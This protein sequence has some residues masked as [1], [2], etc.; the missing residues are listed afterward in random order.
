MTFAAGLPSIHGTCSRGVCYPPSVFFLLR[1]E[2]VEKAKSAKGMSIR[3]VN[4][5]ARRHCHANY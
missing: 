3:N 2:M 5:V 4:P 1:I